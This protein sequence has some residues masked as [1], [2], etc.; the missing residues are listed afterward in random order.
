MNVDPLVSPCFFSVFFLFLSFF[1]YFSLFLYSMLNFTFLFIFIFSFLPHTPTTISLFPRQVLLSCPLPFYPSP[2]FLPCEQAALTCICLGWMSP[3]FGLNAPII[4]LNYDV[5]LRAM[6]LH[7][8]DSYKSWHRT[9][10]PFRGQIKS[11][12]T[13]GVL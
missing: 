3:R 4:L 2:F 5:L 6:L 1:Y 10:E 8:H 12:L 11:M 13:R 9:A 7:L